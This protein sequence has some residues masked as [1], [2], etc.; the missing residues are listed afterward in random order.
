MDVFLSCYIIPGSRNGIKKV[1]QMTEKNSI[2]KNMNERS[3][4]MEYVR[5]QWK[6]C[7]ALVTG[8]GERGDDCVG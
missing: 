3:C 7:M 2:Q 1:T 6:H 8:R 4:W 5:W